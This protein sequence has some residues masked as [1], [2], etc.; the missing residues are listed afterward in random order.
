MTDLLASDQEFAVVLDELAATGQECRVKMNGT[1]I[2]GPSRRR[3]NK[4]RSVG[5]IAH[6]GELGFLA[7]ALVASMGG[8]A[9]AC[10]EG[11]PHH[12]P[13]EPPERN[14]VGALSAAEAKRARKA[15]KLREKGL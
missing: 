13:Y 6:M 10:D 11:K 7:A 4:R 12:K 8:I 9:V 2:T 3:A 1:I 5:A 15:A 14:D